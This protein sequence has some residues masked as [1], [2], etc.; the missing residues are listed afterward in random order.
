MYTSELSGL[1]VSPTYWKDTIDLDDIT[2][3]ASNVIASTA[4]GLTVKQYTDAIWLANSIV[5]RELILLD[6]TC[7]EPNKQD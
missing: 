4:K 2:R 7:L 6:Q 5:A 1:N 3:Q